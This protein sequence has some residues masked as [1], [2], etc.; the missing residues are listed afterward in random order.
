MM[1]ISYLLN[2][3]LQRM[4]NE[5]GIDLRLDQAGALRR[6]EIKLRRIGEDMCNVGRTVENERRENL[7]LARVRD[8]CQQAGC[9]FFHQ[10]DPR[11]AALYIGKGLNDCNYD[12]RGV[13]CGIRVG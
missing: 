10:T 9:D 12:S 13:C 11:G 8:V 1:K 2:R 3:E 7:A 6:L 4:A 5:R